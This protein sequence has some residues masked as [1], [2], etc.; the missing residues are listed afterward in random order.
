MDR[1]EVVRRANTR[2]LREEMEAVARR[3]ASVRAKRSR[4]HRPWEY[5]QLVFMFLV[6]VVVTNL[7]WWWATGHT[8]FGS[9]RQSIFK[10]DGD[11]VF[12]SVGRDILAFI[13]IV[14]VLFFFLRWRKRRRE[15]SSS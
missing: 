13:A 5:V 3:H 4:W 7:L 14:V 10:T 12:G 11:Y 15:Q 8:K 2:A 6:W 1:T 9:D